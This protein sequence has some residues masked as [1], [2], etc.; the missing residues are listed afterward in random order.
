MVDDE[1]GKRTYVLKGRCCDVRGKVG[2]NSEVPNVKEQCA[3]QR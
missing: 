3:R 1:V 2:G